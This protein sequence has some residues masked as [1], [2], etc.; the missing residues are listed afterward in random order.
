MSDSTGQQADFAVTV[1]DL[2]RRALEVPA[3]KRDDFA[4]HVCGGNEN[5]LAVL[6]RIIVK[7]AQ[8]YPL[9]DEQLD[10]SKYLYPSKSPDDRALLTGT[11]IGAYRIVGALGC[12]GMGAVYRAEPISDVVKLP[13]AIKLIKRGMDSQDVVRLFLREREILASLKHPN[14]AQLIDGGITSA[15]QVW[16]AMELVEGKTIDRWCD[17]RFASLRARIKL[18]L[19]VC[20]AVQYAHRNLIVHRDLKPNNLL[21]SDDGQVK[22]LDFGIAKFLDVGSRE[23]NQTRSN[24]RVF[25]PE[26]AAPE[27]LNHE[28]V[29]TATDTYQLGLVL[30]FLL[31]GVRAT[32]QGPYRS[33]DHKFP[34]RL[35]SAWSDNPRRSDLSI[36][37]IAEARSTNG[38]TLRRQLSGDLSRIVG[39]AL[40]P[41]PLRRYSSVEA[42]ADDLRRFDEGRPIMARPDSRWYRAQKFISRH[43]VGFVTA[44]AASVLLIA[45]S[46]FSVQQAHHA[47]LQAQ[48]AEIVRTFLLQL[49][50]LNNPELRQG[51]PLSVHELVDLGERQAETALGSDPDTRIELL[52]IVG[53]LYLSLGDPGSAVSVLQR[54]LQSAASLYAPDDLR[55]A[56]A[57]ID[58][59]GALNGSEEHSGKA[60]ELIRVALS[61]L[62][63]GSAEIANAR[64]DG[65]SLLADSEMQLGHVEAS[66]ALANER[67]AVLAD[68][69]TQHPT[70]IAAAYAQLARFY[71][72]K[73][74]REQSEQAVQHALNLLKDAPPTSP[75]ELMALKSDLSVVLT[76]R[77]RY[78][79]ALRLID[80]TL[81]LSRKIYGD[82]HPVIAGA[83]FQ[84]G[85]I[86]RMQGRF[87]VAIGDYQDAL[88]MYESTF[89]PTNRVVATTLMSLGQALVKTGQVSEALTMLERANRI[90]IDT[91]GPN[92]LYSAIS[93]SALAKARL[94]SGDYPAAEHDYRDALSKYAA[95]GNDEHIFAEAARS[96]LGDSLVRQGKYA[97]AEPLLRRASNRLIKEFGASDFRAID[98][99]VALARC[100]ASEKHTSEAFSILR[101]PRQQLEADPQKNA[102]L[103]SKLAGA[104]VEVSVA[105]KFPQN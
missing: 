16:F 73:G 91:L 105:A 36:E 101:V 49:F 27:Q 8:R 6:R 21:V 63:G 19:D 15:G 54:R 4:R 94:S 58:L 95:S 10:P 89:G 41:D 87:E 43:K 102:A 12:G 26:F 93:A 53:N 78:D 84:R 72:V 103:L 59:A 74:D 7:D 37:K 76:E 35:S 3:D 92:H 60:I 64:L 31:T 46:L 11:T 56:T 17:A 50:A 98:A 13:V 48:R 30:Y 71:Y 25:T 32:R 99:E 5:L 45:L 44:A 34:A 66:I 86:E 77:G 23:E 22:L 85:Q 100:L 52:G 65:L 96:G 79:D 28:S 9:L 69:A 68:A 24:V 20:S 57:R 90:Y 38:S 2:F 40:S 18:F 97:D 29:T 33:G 104:D 39:K 88:H 61:A 67:L 70:E 62:H 1:W 14:I 47:E 42:F 83:L 51:A 82:A 80:E 55:I 81:T 75:A